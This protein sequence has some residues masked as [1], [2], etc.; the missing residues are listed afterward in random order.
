MHGEGKY[1]FADTKRTFE[2]QFVQNEIAG[3]GRLVGVDGS[4]YEGGFKNGLR[5][6]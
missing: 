1:Y 6:G 3:T 2:G 4:V 5:N